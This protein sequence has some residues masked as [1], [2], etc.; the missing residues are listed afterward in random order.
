M[1]TA[2]EV[3]WA[4]MSGTTNKQPP[5]GHYRAFP[6]GV[7]RKHWLVT[8][9]VIVPTESQFLFF[10]DRVLYCRPGCS[11]VVP[12][13]LNTTAT[14]LSQAHMILLPHPLNRDGVS[15]CWSGWSRT[16]D[17][18]IHL[19]RPSKENESGLCVQHRIQ[20]R[21]YSRCWSEAPEIRPV[22]G[23]SGRQAPKTAEVLVVMFTGS[24]EMAEPTQA[25]APPCS[26]AHEEGLAPSPPHHASPHTMQHLP[27]APLRVLLGASHACVLL[28]RE[29]KLDTPGS[30]S[31]HLGSPG[32]GTRKAQKS[33]SA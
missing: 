2:S 6:H 24:W 11:A 20:W 25:P 7:W 1:K 33:V 16:A 4:G 14:S 31:T 3:Q 19:S 18:V 12:S 15:L 23:G 22:A 30:C 10:W 32:P 21:K 26:S 29:W 13:Q 17:L 9:Q 8:L 27:G 5:G 28:L